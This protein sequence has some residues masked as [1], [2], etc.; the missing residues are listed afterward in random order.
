MNE[1]TPTPGAPPP[2][3]FEHWFSTALP[4]EAP[5]RPPV[6]PQGGPG[7][8]LRSRLPF[9]FEPWLKHLLLFLATI[10][11]TWLI[12][13]PVYSATLLAILTA[14]EMGHYLMARRYRVPVSLPYFVPLP[15]GPFGTMG[16]VIRMGSLGANRRQLFDIGVAGPIAGLV[17]ALPACA[18]GIAL[19]K[20]VPLDTLDQAKYIELQSPLLF[21][22]ISDAIKGPMPAGQ[23]LFL[24]PMAF[25]GWAGLFVTALNLLPIGQLDGGHVI[26]ALF[27]RPWSGRVSVLVAVTFLGLAAFYNMSYILFAGIA[28]L[29]RNHPPTW[30]DS[31]PITPVR[32]LIGI[33]LLLMFFLCFTPKPFQF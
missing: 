31:L 6:P 17:L 30:D 21:Q 20:I 1:P 29:M 3:T 11:T 13:G 32:R 2:S 10:A 25:A 5:T 7:A 22:W 33:L 4:P 9:L 16:A 27:D 8:W 18:I 12:G 23:D 26:Y 14:H 19:S 15:I 28:F 24:H